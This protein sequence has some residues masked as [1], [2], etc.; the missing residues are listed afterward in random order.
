VSHAAGLQLGAIDMTTWI[1]PT[2][3]ILLV[4]GYAPLGVRHR[5]DVLHG[6]PANLRTTGRARQPS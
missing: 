3:L 5:L 2:D 4:R 1:R 6:D